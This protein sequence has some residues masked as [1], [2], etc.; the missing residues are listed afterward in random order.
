V[1]DEWN[2][3]GVDFVIFRLEVGEI[4]NFESFS[5]REINFKYLSFFHDWEHFIIII[6]YTIETFT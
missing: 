4:L 5:S 1:F 6:M 2:F 3:W